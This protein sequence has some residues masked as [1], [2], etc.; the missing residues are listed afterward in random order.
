MLTIC[1]ETKPT[2]FWLQRKGLVD[3]EATGT[4]KKNIMSTKNWE[5]LT[6]VDA[7]PFHFSANIIH[8]PSHLRMHSERFLYF[9]GS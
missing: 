8:T 2:G 7:R 3:D 1:S 6:F 9:L 4:G 5:E